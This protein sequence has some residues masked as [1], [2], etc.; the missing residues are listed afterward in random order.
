MHVDAQGHFRGGAAGIG[1]R[2]DFRSIHFRGGGQGLAGGAA[3][4]RALRVVVGVVG[5][6]GDGGGVSVAAGE[7]GILMV[8]A[9]VRGNEKQTSLVSIL[10]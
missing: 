1:A 4:P 5:G 2:A 10:V 7:G 9:M 6:G 8:T 3:G